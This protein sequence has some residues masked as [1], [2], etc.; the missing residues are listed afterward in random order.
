MERRENLKVRASLIHRIVMLVTVATQ[1]A[2][3]GGGVF[4]PAAGG[5]LDVEQIEIDE[6]RRIGHAMRIVAGGAGG[7]IVHNVLLVAFETLIGKKTV[8]AVAFVAEGVSAG[9]FRGVVRQIKRPLQQRRKLRTVRAVR[10]GTAGGGT[11]I[12]I[13]TIHA[14]QQAAGVPRCNKAGHQ[15]ALAGGGDRMI[16]GLSLIHI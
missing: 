8:A 7:L 1:R 2:G 13:V 16:R 6:M 15:T 5:W 11:G 12:A 10:P 9:I 4:D 3:A 14:V